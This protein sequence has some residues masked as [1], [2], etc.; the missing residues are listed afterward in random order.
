MPMEIAHWRRHGRYTGIETDAALAAKAFRAQLRIMPGEIRAPRDYMA[1]CE[2]GRTVRRG[3][4]PGFDFRH[5][6]LFAIPDRQQS[7]CASV[8]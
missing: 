7:A 1:N 3:P 5:T 4:K 2:D 8:G 6:P